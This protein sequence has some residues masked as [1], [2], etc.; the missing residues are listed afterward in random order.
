MGKARRR[1]ERQGYP[2]PMPHIRCRIIGPEV[3][4]GM[5]TWRVVKFEQGRSIQVG[6]RCMTFEDATVRVKDVLS[7]KKT[8]YVGPHRF[9]Q[10]RL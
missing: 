4:N 9:V 2:E 8:I 6:D 10:R 1:V 3:V 7:E 5:N